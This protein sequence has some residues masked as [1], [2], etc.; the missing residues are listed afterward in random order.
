MS[1][2]KK[3]F[4]IGLL[5]LLTT[6]YFT[7]SCSRDEFSGSMIDAKKEAFSSV[8]IDT[9]G[10]PDPQ[11]TWG[12]GVDSYSRAF[13]RAAEPRA[14]EWAATYKVP[15][16][17][18]EGQKNRV[19]KYF[20][21]N[22]YPGGTTMNYSNYFVQQ[23]YKGGYKPLGNS[24]N[25]YSTETYLAANQTT[26]ITGGNNMDKLTAGTQHEHV[27]NFNYGDCGW[28]NDVL[29]NDQPINNGTKHSDQIM[30][31]LNTPT[32]CMGYWN[33]NATYGHDDRYR[34]VSAEEIDRWAS[35]NADKLD[36]VDA[37]VN[38]DWHRDFVGF[39][40]SQVPSDQILVKT[41]EQY[42][43]NWVLVD[44]DLVYATI[45]DGP[46]TYEYI[47]DGTQTIKITEENRA[48]YL[49]LKNAQSQ[50]IP[51]LDN[52]RNMYCGYERKKDDVNSSFYF[53]ETAQYTAGAANNS[54]I[55]LT[56]VP[57]THAVDG[58][59]TQTDNVTALN[60]KFI[61]KMIGDG[62]YPIQENFRTWVAPRDCAD[63]YYSDWIVSLVRAETKNGGG[64]DPSGNFDTFDVQEI[65]DGRIFCEDLGSAEA[66]DIDYNDVVFDAF[67]YVTKTYKVPYTLN[68]NNEKEYDWTNISSRLQSTTYNKTDIN[69]LAA[70]GTISITV[71]GENVNQLLGIEK[72]IMANTY[73][74]GVSPNR[75]GYTNFSNGVSPVKFTVNNSSYTNLSNIPIAVKH[76]N[77]VR[78]LTAYIGDVPQKFSAPVGTPWPA[79]RVEFNS[80]FTGFQSWVSNR[81]AKPWYTKVPTKLY[82]LKFAWSY[83][84]TIGGSIP[85]APTENYSIKVQGRGKKSG[86]EEF[87]T[88]TLDNPLAVGDQIAITGY[89]NKNNNARG[90]L[91]LK[92]NNYS[93]EDEQD[94]NN[95][96]YGSQ[97]N[98][99]VWTVTSEMA[100][101]SSFQISRNLTG[102]NVYITDITII[103][104]L[105]AQRVGNNSSG[106]NSGNNNNR[107]TNNGGSDGDA[108]S[109][110]TLTGTE[111][112]V[113]TTA[114]SSNSNLT[115]DAS[116]IS[117]TPAAT[118]YV[119]GTGEG[120]V[121]VNGV[122]ATTVATRAAA[123][124][125]KSCTLTPKQMGLG[126]LTITGGNF[127]VYR[128]SYQATTLPSVSQPAGTV[129]FGGNGQSKN[130]ANWGDNQLKVAGSNLSGLTKNSKIRVAGIGFGQGNVQIDV[131]YPWQVIQNQTYTTNSAVGEVSVEFELTTEQQAK[132]LLAGGLVV[133]GNNFIMKYVTVENPSSTG[134]GGTATATINLV[135]SANAITAQNSAT[136][137]VT[138]ASTG[139]SYANRIV[140][141]TTRLVGKAT[142][143][144]DEK[145]YGYWNFKIGP[146]NSGDGIL[147]EISNNLSEYS[148][149][150][151]NDVVN[152]NLLLTQEL[153]D[154]I[155]KAVGKDGEYWPGGMITFQGH[156]VTLTELKL[157]NCLAAE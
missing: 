123:G 74:N 69:L 35:Q 105:G 43:E 37:A 39:D 50:R 77:E 45:N 66:T 150:K 144:A 148:G 111:V 10:E 29:D 86:Q 119:Y 51:F 155:V 80:A 151:Q 56:N 137:I 114:L 117:N 1:G 61:N 27:N 33:S 13:T 41:N 73:V 26:Y 121:Y 36:D 102:T 89:R 75:S 83:E 2:M 19:M 145:T 38:D 65:I 134:G 99:F 107:N 71:A 120:S 100:G 110:G 82:N 96:Y 127:T 18:T 76:G 79:E 49:Y 109:F 153:K 23:V 92:F 91:Y 4:G 138:D 7:S 101:C 87:I 149:W 152:I 15:A 53:T 22:Q 116:D 154:K 106:N 12:F 85:N 128:L 54:S 46:K 32:T 16:P 8:F 157:T 42:D 98:T 124:V 93:I 118:I 94:Y 141:G 131:E 108:P 84:G 17:L 122:E 125:V 63:G 52:K 3:F 90:T 113:N 143:N 24:S 132:D 156:N 104:G 133:Q 70:G 57:Y 60:L 78:E 64:D 147:P 21:Y 48:Q 97:P 68:N 34:L 6:A 135:T 44:Y 58:G 14:N 126:G 139:R 55:E 31:M 28:N 11:H 88:V 136:Q 95:L 103:G 25:N 67:T 146:G 5:A 112:A 40:F 140:G 59:G 115:V 20:Q 129:L 142:I 47:W 62:Y 81:A 130:M 9:Y 72:T 30:L